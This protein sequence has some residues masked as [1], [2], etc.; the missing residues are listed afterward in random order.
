[1]SA[2]IKLAPELSPSTSGPA[3][4]FLK[5]V[6]ICKPAA[7]KAEPARRHVNA[8]GSLKCQIISLAFES[9]FWKRATYKSVIEMDTL[10]N[11]R[12]A[13]NRF[14]NSRVRMIPGFQK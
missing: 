10:P 6:C 4:G 12:S 5:S 13:M 11:N 2:T 7:D 3:R 1:M 9:V 8:L 14:I